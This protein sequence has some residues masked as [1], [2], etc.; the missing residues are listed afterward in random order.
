ML[1]KIEVF[2]QLNFSFLFVLIK[3]MAAAARD[4]GA[5]AR[6]QGQDGVAQWGSAGSSSANFAVPRSEKEFLQHMRA[7]MSGF[8]PESSL[9]ASGKESMDEGAIFGRAMCSQGLSAIARD[10]AVRDLAQEYPQYAGYRCQDCLERRNLA[11]RP[12]FDF[13]HVMQHT[14]S[15]LCVPDGLLPGHI[16]FVF[17]HTQRDTLLRSGYKELHGDMTSMHLPSD[18]LTAFTPLQEE[19][20]QTR[21]ATKRARAADAAANE[22][23]NKIQ[24]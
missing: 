21:P 14:E 24:I 17:T 1:S 10:A 7:V 2:R 22:L 11:L 3:F 6:P 12:P 18:R 8:V 16:R 23:N 13:I 20:S 19:F 4:G 15:V 9:V 5:A